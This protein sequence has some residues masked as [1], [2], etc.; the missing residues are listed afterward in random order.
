MA[1][2]KLTHVRGLGLLGH[3]FLSLLSLPLGTPISLGSSTGMGEMYG[4]VYDDKI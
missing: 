1:T 4:G 3:S 2:K